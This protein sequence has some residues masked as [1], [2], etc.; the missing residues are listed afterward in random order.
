MARKNTP[1]VLVVAVAAVAAAGLYLSPGC[2]TYTEAAGRI[3][4][5]NYQRVAIV[6]NL[7]RRHEEYFIPMY[8]Q[9]FPH[10]QLVERRDLQSVFDEQDLAPDRLNP[11]TRA[12]LREV[13]GV[14]AIVYPSITDG[15]FNQLSLKV[16]DTETGQIMAAVMV[17]RRDGWLGPPT[18]QQMMRRAIDALAYEVL[19]E[20]G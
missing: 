6:S 16:I 1:M 13:W 3:E 20:D 15:T 19:H 12:R 2:A 11:A 8:M 18:E 17:T 10:Q 4:F 5:L 14:Q 7:E 9:E